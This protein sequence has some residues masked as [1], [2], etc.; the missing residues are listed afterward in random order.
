MRVIGLLIY[1]AMYSLGIPFCISQYS[2]KI[3]NVIGEI[4]FRKNSF[5]SLLLWS[6]LIYIV[7]LSFF[8][9][10]GGVQIKGP[11]AHINSM[12]FG[13]PPTYAVRFHR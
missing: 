6:N 2:P 8:L 10:G 5:P 7:F 11:R 13:L 3:I 12:C 1:I 9:G 4:R